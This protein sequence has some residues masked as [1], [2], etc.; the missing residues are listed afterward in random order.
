MG[1]LSTQSSACKKAYIRLSYSKVNCEVSQSPANEYDCNEQRSDL[2]VR[3]SGAFF[4]TNAAMSN[5]TK[6][7]SRTSHKYLTFLVGCSQFDR[8]SDM[9]RNGDFHYF[10]LRL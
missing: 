10:N 4:R 6:L 2:F 5:D 9:L 3:W 1:L 8:R 7:T